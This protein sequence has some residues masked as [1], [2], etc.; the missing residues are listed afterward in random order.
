MKIGVLALQGGFILHQKILQ[1]L[2]IHSISVRYPD[3]L[4]SCNGLIVPGGE[5]TSISKLIK[6]FK[7][8]EP[9]KTFAEKKP[10]FGTCAGLIVMS[11]SVNDSKIE[12]LS[13]LNIDVNRNSWGRQIDSFTKSF[14]INLNDQIKYKGVFIRAP[15]ITSVCENVIVLAKVKDEPVLIQD[16]FHLGTTFHP[17]L[18][19]DTRIHQYFVSLAAA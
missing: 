18:T 2:N 16:K 1:K 17:E 6:K 10:V 11:K 9:I 4:S 12:K 13:I 7:F 15:K 14:N 19:N 5:S 8:I 3:Q